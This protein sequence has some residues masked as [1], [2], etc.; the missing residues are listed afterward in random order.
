[1]RQFVNLRVLL[2][3]IYFWTLPIILSPWPI[4]C[5]LSTVAYSHIFLLLIQTT[6]PL[7]ITSLPSLLYKANCCCWDHL[8]VVP[9]G[10]RHTQYGCV[11]TAPS[12]WAVQWDRVVNIHLEMLQ[13][14]YNPCEYKESLRTQL[15][16][17]SW[18]QLP[19]EDMA[20]WL[21]VVSVVPFIITG[22]LYYVKG[23]LGT[24]MCNGQ[25]W[26]CAGWNTSQIPCPEQ[27]N[28]CSGNTLST[29]RRCS[30][31]DFTCRLL[32]QNWWIEGW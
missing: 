8:Y 23:S 28:F 21:Q 31:R 32:R 1:M 25:R 2:H 12:F 24:G 4:Q 29:T 17:V 27:H 14:K 19:C 7:L 9:V 3:R 26:N 22:S 10:L 15:K 11:P 13:D 5:S 6:K 30:E 18:V 16:C 20:G